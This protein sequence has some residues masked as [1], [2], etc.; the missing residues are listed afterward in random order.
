MTFH[1]VDARTQ[2]KRMRELA[3]ESYRAFLDFDKKVFA[4][5]ALPVK[6]K[7]LIALG[8]AHI[9]QCP[10]C[11]DA[12]TERASDAAASAAEIAEVTFVAMAMAAGARGDAHPAVA[13]PRAHAARGPGGRR[14][15]EPPAARARGHDPPGRPGDLRLPAARPARGPPRGDDRARGDGPHRR[16]GDPDAGGHPGRAVAGERTL[17][18]LW[19]G[20]VAAERPLRARLLLRPHARGGGDRSRAP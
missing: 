20:A 6:T 12:H 4:A 19:A 17:A 14:G 15:R 18:P 10:W 3:P 9:T 5:G 8:I 13:A 1:G 7:E 16:P 2:F 11:I